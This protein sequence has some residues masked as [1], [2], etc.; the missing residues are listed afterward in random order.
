MG[1]GVGGE[2]MA[3]KRVTARQAKAN[4]IKAENAAYAASMAK[5]RQ[6]QGGA[7]PELADA[8]AMFKDMFKNIPEALR[9]R[10]LSSALRKGANA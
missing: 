8:E 6:E 7:P 3:K 1:A 5:A 2:R 4:E 10:G 9:G